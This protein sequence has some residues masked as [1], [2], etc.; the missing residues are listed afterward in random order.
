MTTIALAAACVLC[1]CAA[2]F[3]FVIGSRDGGQLLICVGIIF[4]GAAAATLF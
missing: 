2:R 3:L 4:G 1:I